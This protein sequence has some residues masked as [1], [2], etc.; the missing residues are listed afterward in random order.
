MHPHATSL[1]HRLAIVH[2]GGNAPP[3]DDIVDLSRWAIGKSKTVHVDA[4]SGQRHRFR[5]GRADANGIAER[6]LDWCQETGIGGRQYWPVIA[7]E[8]HLYLDATGHAAVSARQLQRALG[9]VCKKGLARIKG[10]DVDLMRRM[11]KMLIAN[12]WAVEGGAGDSA[13]PQVRWYD[14]PERIERSQSIQLR[15]AA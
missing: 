10:A 4:A 3:Y 12:K 7:W 9:K 11:R 1:T 13:D 15:G 5:M 8:Y 2:S 14:L 6:F